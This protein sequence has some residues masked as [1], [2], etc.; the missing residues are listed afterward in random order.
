MFSA[1]FITEN[2]ST[3]SLA[4]GVDTTGIGVKAN[5]LNT[6]TMEHHL[7]E[8][9]HLTGLKEF[10]PVKDVFTNSITEIAIHED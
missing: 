1:I 7:T 4:P 3:T 2:I 5:G 8:N 10:K 6:L 9:T